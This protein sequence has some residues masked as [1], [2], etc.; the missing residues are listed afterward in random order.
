MLVVEREEFCDVKVWATR[1]LPERGM[2][3]GEESQLW[4]REVSHF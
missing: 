3:R 2:S 4:V 1:E